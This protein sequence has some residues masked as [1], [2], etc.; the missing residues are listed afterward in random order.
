MQDAIEANRLK[1]APKGVLEAMARSISPDV[2]K[3][4]TARHTK[5]V[6]LEVRGRWW[7]RVYGTY[8]A[9]VPSRFFFFFSLFTKKKKKNKKELSRLCTNFF[10]SRRVQEYEGTSRLA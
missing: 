4:F 8:Y 10:F 1:G 9:R 3:A 6:A 5:E 2:Y 7:K